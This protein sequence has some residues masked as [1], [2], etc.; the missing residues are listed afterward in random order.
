MKNKY[1]IKKTKT[2][3]IVTTNKGTYSISISDFES[4]ASKNTNSTTN[5]AND[6]KLN[7]VSVD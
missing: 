7:K 1:T 2:H 4:L 5:N 3:Y 6:R